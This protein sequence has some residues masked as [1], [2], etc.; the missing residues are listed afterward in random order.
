M[1]NTIT[2][3][4]IP[5]SR[6]K[7][8]CNLIFILFLLIEEGVIIG[9][10]AAI[11]YAIFPYGVDAD[12]TKNIE[13]Q[14]GIPF[15]EDNQREF[16]YFKLYLL[17]VYINTFCLIGFGFLTVYLRF[18][19]WS[20][21]GFTYLSMA[22]GIQLYILFSAFWIRVNYRDWIRVFEINLIQIISSIKAAV[23]LLIVYGA[24]LGKVDAFQ[25]SVIAII[26]MFLYALNEIVVCINILVLDIGGGFTIHAFSAFFGVACSWIYSPKS[27]CK[28]NP[29]NKASYGTA[30]LSFLGTFFLWIMFPA[31]NSTSHFSELPTTSA[32]IQFATFPRVLY[33]WRVIAIMNTFWSLTA[34]TI[35]TFLVSFIIKGGKFSL[36]HILNATLAGGVAIAASADLF[37]HAVHPMYIGGIAGIICTLCFNYLTPLYEMCYLFDTRGVLNLHGIPSLIGAIASSI[38]AL[39]SVGQTFNLNNS[40]EGNRFNNRSNYSQGGFQ[41]LGWLIS[42]GIGLGGGILTGLLLRIWRFSGIPEDTFGDHIW[43]KMDLDRTTT[44]KPLPD[45]TTNATQLVQIN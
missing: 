24:L 11:S 23:G 3:P 10:Y 42:M 12:Q 44:M 4:M 7:T 17:F 19:R 38:A 14:P 29:N 32:Y 26:F 37:A 40:I 13:F 1:I 18:H 2:N 35:C 33:T 34:S 15:L 43:W 9:F 25:M 22:L 41:F 27:N 45:N 30:T 6:I 20:S 28:E 8:A 36:D 16:V 21:L 39:T 31:F 5:V